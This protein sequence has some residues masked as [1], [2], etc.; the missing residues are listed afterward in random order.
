MALLEVLKAGNPVLKQ[1]SVPVERVD[2]KL[3]KLMDDMAETMYENDGVGLAAPQIGQNIRLV[4]IDCQDEHGLLELINP[5]ITFKE[6]EVV[7]TEGCLSVPDIY[8]EVTRA[9]KVKVEFMNRRGKR[10]HLTATGLLAR[11]IQHELDHLEGQLFIDIAT[12]VHR[13]NQS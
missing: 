8:G 2:K 7:D 4:V 10:Q 6:G 11:C 9:A 12:S 13:G 5:V 3:K 1:V